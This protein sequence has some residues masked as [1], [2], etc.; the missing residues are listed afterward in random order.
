AA[1]AEEMART[2]QERRI[3]GTIDLTDHYP[4]DRG[5]DYLPFFLTAAHLAEVEVD[6]ETGKPTVR[7]IV[8]AHDVGRAIN[9]RDAAGQ[10]EGGVVM[11]LGSAL[12]EEFTPG[13]SR[14]FSTYALPTATS[15]PEIRVRLVEVPGRH[16]AFGVKG[17]GEATF[18]PTPPAIIN[19]VSR[20]IG[21]RVRRTPATPERILAAMA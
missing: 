14:G 9:P 3:R 11:G 20:A 4:D 12:I 19:A 5:S 17:L 8:A 13:V 15:V 2:G 7:L 6:L 10:I 16:A 1:V 18:L 21:R